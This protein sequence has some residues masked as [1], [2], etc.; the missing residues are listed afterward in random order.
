MVSTDVWVFFNQVV[1]ML[2]AV[3]QCMVNFLPPVQPVSHMTLCLCLPAFIVAGC[4][5]DNTWQW[6]CFAGIGV[7][8]V[9]ALYN[10]NHVVEESVVAGVPAKSDGTPTPVNL[11][12]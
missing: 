10:S 7:L 11:G 9:M 4:I 1:V 12:I 8:S 3:F 2:I 5:H 6:G